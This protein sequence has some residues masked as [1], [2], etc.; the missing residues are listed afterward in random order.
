MKYGQ[1]GMKKDL[2]S[3]EPEENILSKVESV[4]Y[5]LS[6]YEIKNQFFLQPSSFYIKPICYFF[7]IVGD[8][9]YWKASTLTFFSETEF[10]GKRF[11]TFHR[12]NRGEEFDF[13]PR[14]ETYFI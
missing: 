7:R 13:K 5:I 4:R 10:R 1:P 2:D 12:Y 11:L 9:D 14:Y 3:L 8:L 6:G